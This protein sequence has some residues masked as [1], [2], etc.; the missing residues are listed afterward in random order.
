[1]VI[2]NFSF[3]FVVLEFELRALYFLGKHST[4]RALPLALNFAFDVCDF[5]VIF[6]LKQPLSL[7][8]LI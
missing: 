1:V 7:C 3:S 2:P 5:I 4:T 8:P 6:N